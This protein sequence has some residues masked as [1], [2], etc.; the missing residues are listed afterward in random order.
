MNYLKFVYSGTIDTFYF[1]LDQQMFKQKK[2]LVTVWWQMLKQGFRFPV[3][4][5][6]LPYACTYCLS[7][8]LIS[9][10]DNLE[11]IVLFK[12]MMR[13]TQSDLL[14]NKQHKCHTIKVMPDTKSQKGYSI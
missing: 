2:S 4:G 9:I 7:F 14:S 12:K 6:D 11:S 3:M 5:S 10:M 8:T 1:R 13:V